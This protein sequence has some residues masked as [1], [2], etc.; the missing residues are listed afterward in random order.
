MAEYFTKEGLEKLKK[1]LDYLKSTRRREISQ[2]IAE[3]ASKG[4]LSENAEYDAAK[5]AQG[6][7]EAQI[8]KLED[9][10]AHARVVDESQIDTSRVQALSTVHI[11]NHNTGMEL[12]YMLVSETEANLKEGK[13]SVQS[14]IGKALLGKQK[15]EIVEA[16]VP[17][18]VLKLEVINITIE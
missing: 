2:E 6:M 14:P 13:I 12:K 8:A 9:V 3:A 4:D 10:Y 16:K 5:D 1:E 11:I 7:L 18:G 15:G 17:A